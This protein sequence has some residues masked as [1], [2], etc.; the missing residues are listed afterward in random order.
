[1]PNS[2]QSNTNGD[3][4]ARLTAIERRLT[5]L[6]REIDNKAITIDPSRLY[7]VNDVAQIFDCGKSNVY[8]L[9]KSGAIATVSVGAGNSGVRVLGRDILAFVESRRSGGPAPTI[10]IKNLR[11]TFAR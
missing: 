5:A 9:I 11:G 6:E 2:T 4:N 7:R 10:A 8:E 1:M 3:L